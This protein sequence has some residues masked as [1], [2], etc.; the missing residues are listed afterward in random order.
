M[1]DPAELIAALRNLFDAYCERRD[2]G[3][4][5]VVHTFGPQHMPVPP[6][7]VVR[8]WEVVH[9]AL[10]PQAQAPASIASAEAEKVLDEYDLTC[11][12]GTL[13]MK[14]AAKAAVLACM[15][16]PQWPPEG[17]KLVPVEPTDAMLENTVDA[18]GTIRAMDFTTPEERSGPFLLPR[19][20]W[21]A[22]IA[23]T[24]EPTR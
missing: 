7:L 23:A 6:D 1:A 11:M 8:A 14:M 9:D 16:A 19:Y 2:G 13:E 21:R 4:K 24:P 5:Y 18:K 15:R 12:T 20:V 10:R 17:W 3:Q 22:M